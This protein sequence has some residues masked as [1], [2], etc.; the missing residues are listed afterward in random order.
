V[1]EPALYARLAAHAGVSA[2]C[3]TRIYP[4]VIPQ[5][6]TPVYP[7]LVYQRI[8]ADHIASLAGHSGLC[9]ARVQIDCWGRSY[10]DTR[11]LAAVLDNAM[12][13]DDEDF[14]AL[15]LSDLDDYEPETQLYRVSTDFSVWF[16]T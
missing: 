5:E 12:T 3:G 1:L 16:E 2:L 14:S 15:V 6:E 11:E 7:V 8:S 13:A 10:A 9:N 4:L